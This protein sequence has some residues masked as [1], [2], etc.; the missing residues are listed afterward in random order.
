[1]KGICDLLLAIGLVH[2]LYLFRNGQTVPKIIGTGFELL[3]MISMLCIGSWAIF[4]SKKAKNEINRGFDF[5]NESYWDKARNSFQ[6]MSFKKS[7]N[8]TTQKHL[9]LQVGSKIDI[10]DTNHG[11]RNTIL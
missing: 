4:V 5:V 9:S 7:G 6:F 8:D 1:M 11:K 3:T 10:A 2:L